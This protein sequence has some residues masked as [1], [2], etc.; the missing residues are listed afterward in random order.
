MPVA[1][2]IFAPLM[3]MAE[4]LKEWSQSAGSTFRISTITLLK[5][6]IYACIGRTLAGN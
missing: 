6:T 4:Q 5:T 2:R 3:G 1:N